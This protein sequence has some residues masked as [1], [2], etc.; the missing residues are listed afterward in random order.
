[1]RFELYAVLG[2]KNLAGKLRQAAR[3]FSFEHLAQNP[4]CFL[5]HRA[6]A[7]GRS[8]SQLR[9]QSLVYF[10]DRDACHRFTSRLALQSYSSI[11]CNGTKDT[12]GAEVEYRIGGC[13]IATSR[14]IRAAFA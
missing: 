8:D 11:A 4:S 1:M 12:A 2:A 7:F 10:S 14:A 5:L 3:S 9:F 6:T 13:R